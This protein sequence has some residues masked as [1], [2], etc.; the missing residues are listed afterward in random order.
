[1]DKQGFTPGEWAY[2]GLAGKHDFAIYPVA[3]GR[4]IALV[5][6]FNEA[7]ARLI[8]AAPDLYRVCEA[9]IESDGLNLGGQV[10]RSELRGLAVQARAAL[11][12]MGEGQG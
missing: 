11:A 12:A 2:Q 6:D 4:D 9:V 5:R 1:M 3:T 8:A 7:N 10:L